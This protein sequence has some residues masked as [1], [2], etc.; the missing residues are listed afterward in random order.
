MHAQ[1]AEEEGLFTMEDVIG[2][3]TEKMVR[4]HPHVFGETDD[5]G[6]RR[7]WGAQVPAG[8]TSAVQ[9]PARQIMARS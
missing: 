9:S 1:I 2:G 8:R 6:K 5:A 7:I 3:I 4:R